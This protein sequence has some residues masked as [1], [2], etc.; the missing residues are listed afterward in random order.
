[1][2]R[3]KVTRKQLLKEPDEFLTLSA[4]TIQW[5]RANSRRLSWTL[6]AILLVAIVFSAMRFF[7]ARAEAKSLVLYDQQKTAYQK[8][9]KEDGTPQKAWEQLKPSL[10]DIIRKYSGKNGAK[11]ATIFFGDIS[12]RAGKYDE[13]VKRYLQ[14]MDDYRDEP[15]IHDLIVISLAY[16]YAGKKDTPAAEKYFRQIVEGPRPVLK[17]EALLNL[18]ALY[19]QSGKPE[20]EKAAL[21]KIVAEYDNS[22][23]APVAREKLA[24]L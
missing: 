11:M 7:S 1:M 6:A 3:K 9:L 13:A 19:A 17:P 21:Q 23:Y 24:L 4:K 5:A 15:V 10:E 22:V 18:A 2:A 12:Y 8:I 14:A 20:K 16:A